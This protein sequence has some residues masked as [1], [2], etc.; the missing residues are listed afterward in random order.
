LI[1]L[2]FF[3]SFVICVYL[4]PVLPFTDGANTSKS[5]SSRQSLT[6]LTYDNIRWKLK[7]RKEVRSRD[8]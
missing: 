2:K 3:Y 8:F 4:D 1:F 5:S 6:Y 7:I